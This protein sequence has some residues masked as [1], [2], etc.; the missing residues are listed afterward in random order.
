MPLSL[1]P[2]LENT[3][4]RLIHSGV[5]SK[6]TTPTEWVNSMVIVEK[7][8]GSLRICIDAQELNDNTMRQY[9][10]VPTPEEISSKLYGSCIF[11]VIDMADCYWHIELDD[12]S[13]K[14][15]TFNPPFGSH[16]FNRLPFGISCASD[17]AQ[18][19]VEKYLGV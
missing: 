13:S 7:K 1:L 16:K 15:C 12:Y 4:K 8:N 14:L 5:I 11:T 17:A 6:V 10:T 18:H 9:N 19:M 2:K 3:L